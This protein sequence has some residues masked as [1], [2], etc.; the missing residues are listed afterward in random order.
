MLVRSI[1]S[2]SNVAHVCD[3]VSFLV[4][5]KGQ[6]GSTEPLPENEVLVAWLALC[7]DPIRWYSPSAFLRGSIVSW[8]RAEDR[9]QSLEISKYPTAPGKALIFPDS[10]KAAFS[11]PHGRIYV[12]NLETRRAL[13][14]FYLGAM[15]CK[16][17]PL[18]HWSL[19]YR[20]VWV[21]PL[22]SLEALI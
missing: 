9:A 12:S 13:S 8:R 19:H 6:G 10:V 3:Y 5:D 1:W 7:H 4:P 17:A 2:S 21:T 11:V 22:M 14:R 15:A 16:W 20:M 18:S